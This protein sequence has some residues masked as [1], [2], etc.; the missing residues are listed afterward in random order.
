MVA[1]RDYYEILGVTRGASVD[2][3]KKAYRNLARKH[4]PD[5]DK[6]PG[7]AERFKEINEAYQVLSDSQKRAAYDRYGHA[8]FKAGGQAGSAGFGFD[9]FGFGASGTSGQWGPFTYTYSTTGGDSSGADLSDPF[10]IFESVFGFRGF[11]SDREPKRGR[12]LNY[13]MEV[14]F[15]EAVTGGEKVV[16]V[17]GKKLHLKIPAGA[18]S[19]TKI[20]FGGEGEAG[21]GRDGRP[22]PRGDLFITLKVGR[23]SRFQREGDDIVSQ[24]EIGY[25]QAVLGETLTMETVQ[26]RV[27]LKIPGGTQSGSVFRIKGKGVRSRRGVGDHYVRVIIKVPKSLSK[28]E[29]EIFEELKRLES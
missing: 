3:I 26:G 9:P 21:R 8:A 14:D 23:H 24:E 13:V 16:E 22:L 18:G 10:D 12:D 27:K 2:E 28:R 6:S 11:G 1:S 19:G 5:V 29:R 25:P 20:R 17:N 15:L 4:H 7:A